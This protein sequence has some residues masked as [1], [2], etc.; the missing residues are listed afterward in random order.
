[1]SHIISVPTSKNAVSLS[2]TKKLLHLKFVA[3]GNTTI[4][5]AIT[6]AVLGVLFLKTFLTN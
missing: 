5:D 3:T 2:M 1:M 4:P 6:K